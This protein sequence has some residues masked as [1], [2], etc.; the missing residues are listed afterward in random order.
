MHFFTTF[1][2]YFFA[3][4]LLFI[5]LILILIQSLL[6]NQKLFDTAIKLLSRLFP[7]VFGIRVKVIGKENIDPDKTYIFMANHVNIFDIVILYGYIPH[8]FRAVELEDHFSWPVWGTITQKAGN[9][10]ISHSNPRAALESLN[11]AGTAISQG[12]SIA[13][14]PEGHRTRDGKLQPFMRGPFRLAKKTNVDIIPIVMK[15]LWDR[16]SVHSKIVHPG[17]VEIL[18]GDPITS[19]SYKDISDRKLN[20]HVRKIM[21]RMLEE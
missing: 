10:P 8:F 13:I 9:I 2:G 5:I 20:I 4:P 17:T 3:V 15:G 1:A 7:A 6:D 11:K 18:I 16:K 21:L 14:L 19:E 12:T